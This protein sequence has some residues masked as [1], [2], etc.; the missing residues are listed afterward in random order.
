MIRELASTLLPLATPA[1]LYFFWAWAMRLRAR[2][3]AG[4]GAAAEAERVYGSEAVAAE[5]GLGSCQ[6]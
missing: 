4:K 6:P 1:L 3:A 2:A 5:A